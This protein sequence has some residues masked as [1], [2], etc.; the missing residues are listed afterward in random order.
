MTTRPLRGMTSNI[1]YIDDAGYGRVTVSGVV[2]VTSTATGQYPP[3]NGPG[4]GYS[5]QRKLTPK[6]KAERAKLKKE[7][8]EKS[9]NKAVLGPKGSRWR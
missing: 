2:T 7:Q 9:R 8:D 3:Y 1:V 5:N 6:E 4:M